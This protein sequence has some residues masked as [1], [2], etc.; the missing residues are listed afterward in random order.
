MRL[1][2]ILLGSV[3]LV[4]LMGEKSRMMEA[5]TL[6]EESMVDLWLDLVVRYSQLEEVVPSRFC[7]AFASVRSSD[8]S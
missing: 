8:F 3:G 6:A 7:L 2:Q 5:V 4:V 1:E